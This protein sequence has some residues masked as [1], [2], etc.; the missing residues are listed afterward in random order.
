MASSSKRKRVS[1]ADAD[2]AEVSSDKSPTKAKRSKKDEKGAVEKRLGRYRSSCPQNILDRVY[3]VRVPPSIRPNALN[4]HS[5]YVPKVCIAY[6][7]RE[8]THSTRYCIRFFMVQRSGMA[9]LREEFK[10]LGSTGNV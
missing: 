7:I 6:A 10:V 5:G 9:G 3:R 8:F 1:N 4:S 2:Y